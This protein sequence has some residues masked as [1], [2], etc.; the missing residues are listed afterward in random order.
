MRHP[1]L[2]LAVLLGAPA[3]GHAAPTPIEH[4]ASPSLR[5]DSHTAERTPVP[6]GVYLHT[7]YRAAVLNAR[8]WL[9]PDAGSGPTEIRVS[10][11]RVVLAIGWHEG[12][13]L[14]AAG[15]ADADAV[16]RG[17]VAVR[18]RT[19]ALHLQALGSPAAPKYVGTYTYVGPVTAAIDAPYFG[20]LFK[21]CFMADGAEWCFGRNQ[22]R[23]PSGT[24]HAEL[25]LDASEAPG[26]GSVLRVDGEQE[27]WVFR[28]RGQGWAV[29]KSGWASSDG[30]RPPD[31]SRP[32]QVLTPVGKRKSPL[33]EEA[34]R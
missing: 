10:G 26:P 9:E 12:G 21:G 34:L 3:I 13:P 7:K 8:M 17:C 1:L 24:R 2:A 6:D 15:S 5:C 16:A 4:A 18:V 30:Y 33:R 29:F 32:W 19:L 25:V 28:P 11:G 23:T 31:W 14:R 20:L 22:V 27:M